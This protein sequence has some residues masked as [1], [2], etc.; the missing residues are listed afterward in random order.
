MT[1][2]EY[3]KKFISPTCWFQTIGLIILLTQN[4]KGG[5]YVVLVHDTSSPVE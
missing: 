5:V 2:S 3:S 4:S 1:Y